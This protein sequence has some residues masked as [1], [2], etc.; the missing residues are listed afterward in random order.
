M[1]LTPPGYALGQGVFVA[2]KKKV[3][4][5]LDSSKSG[6]ADREIIVADSLARAVTWR[7]GK[8]R[9][10][11]TGFTPPRLALMEITN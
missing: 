7:R 8:Y 6:K 11:M 2:G 9:C 10:H 5:I 1:A 4:L 3:S